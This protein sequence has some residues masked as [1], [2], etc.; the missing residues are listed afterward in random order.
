M[1][2]NALLTKIQTEHRALHQ[3]LDGYVPVVDKD[4][5]PHDIV[6]RLQMLL[7]DVGLRPASRP[8]PRTKLIRQRRR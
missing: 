2:V 5:K 3:M 6:S 7:E 1:K 8:A 4:G